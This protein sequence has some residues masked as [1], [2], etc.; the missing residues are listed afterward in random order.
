MPATVFPKERHQ[1]KAS[2]WTH[3]HPWISSPPIP[4][5]R[6]R[7]SYVQ[8]HYW[9]RA[10]TEL[11]RFTDIVW[12]V[13]RRGSSDRLSQPE[14]Y[15][16]T[17]VVLFSARFSTLI[18]SCID[19]SINSRKHVSL[20][21]PS[22]SYSNALALARLLPVPPEMGLRIE[23]DQDTVDNT[24]PHAQRVSR[25]NRAPGAHA[26]IRASVAGSSRKGQATWENSRIRH[27]RP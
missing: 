22:D 3:R 4:T 14:P 16:G 1:R 25:R 8:W 7:E 21:T 9:T 5:Y 23:V 26:G 12:S 13:N 15:N 17:F 18:Y 2:E 24:N 10:N 27:W 19:T 20:S 6:S 11:R